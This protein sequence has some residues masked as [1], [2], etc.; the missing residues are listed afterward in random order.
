MSKLYPVGD[1]V[2]YIVLIGVPSWE[3]LTKIK[4]EL[5]DK[6]IQFA[7]F[8]DTDFDFGTAAVVTIPLNPDER[9]LLKQHKL[10]KEL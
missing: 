9:K 7:D 1:K 5:E 4:K 8:H 2:P 3:E 10:Y 6:G